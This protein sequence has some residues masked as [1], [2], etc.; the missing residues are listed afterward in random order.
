MRIEQ[1]PERSVV[2]YRPGT[3][4]KIGGIDLGHDASRL[5]HD[6]P[7]MKCLWNTSDQTPATF[8]GGGLE[9]SRQMR[10]LSPLP[11]KCFETSQVFEVDEMPLACVAPEIADRSSQPD[12][13]AHLPGCTDVAN[14]SLNPLAIVRRKCL[15]TINSIFHLTEAEFDSHVACEGLASHHISHPSMRMIKTS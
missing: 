1:A 3:R 4:A 5:I 13:H 6:S 9:L 11:E 2:L 8:A 10:L 14:F 7:E 12:R 15:L